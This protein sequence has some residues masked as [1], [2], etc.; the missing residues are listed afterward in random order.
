MDLKKLQKREPQKPAAKAAP[1]AAETPA[2]A[3]RPAAVELVSRTPMGASSTLVKR[4]RGER[5]PRQFKLTEATSQ[6]FDIAAA[7]AGFNS[8]QRSEFFEQVWLFYKENA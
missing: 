4:P 7:E 1:A 2:P 5:V 3:S 6:E 8:R